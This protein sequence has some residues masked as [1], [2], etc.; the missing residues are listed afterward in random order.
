MIYHLFF[1]RHLIDLHVI[2][3]SPDAPPEE[4]VQLN[5]GRRLPVVTVT[6]SDEDHTHFSRP[7]GISV[8]RKPSVQDGPRSRLTSRP[9]LVAEL[10]EDRD[11]LLDCWN[12]PGL[13]AKSPQLPLICDLASGL[14]QL[15]LYGRTSIVLKCL[16]NLDEHLKMV[17]QN[18]RS[19][20][21]TKVWSIATVGAP[22]EWYI[23]KVTK[24]SDADFIH[25]KG[26]M[27]K[28]YPVLIGHIHSGFLPL[29]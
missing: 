12:E 15:L 29:N 25:P 13:S 8:Y 28:H 5:V 3:I 19:E 16:Q 9:L 24:Y 21:I 4:Y 6:A 20:R 26:G 2:P 22:I 14:N 27:T 23:P 1:E 18:V 7:E 10:E 17:S 11:A